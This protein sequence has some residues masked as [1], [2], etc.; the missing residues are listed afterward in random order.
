MGFTLEKQLKKLKNIKIL[1]L[2]EYTLNVLE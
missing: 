1:G 2:G